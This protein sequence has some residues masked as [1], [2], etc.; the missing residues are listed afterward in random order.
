M[1]A[2][3]KLIYLFPKRS[4]VY[5]DLGDV[6]VNYTL[7][8]TELPVSNDYDETHGIIPRNPGR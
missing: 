3:T 1:Y 4:I 2:V 5:V 8:N 6:E 7:E